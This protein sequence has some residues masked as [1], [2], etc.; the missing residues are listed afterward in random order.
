MPVRYTPPRPE[1]LLPVP[2]VRLGTAAAQIKRWQRDDVLLVGVRSRHARPPGVFTQNRFCA[3]PVIVCRQHLEGAGTSARAGR[4]RRE[5]QRRHRRGRH[6]GGRGHVRRR[7]VD[8]RLRAE[9]GAAVLDRRDHGAAAG[10]QDRRGAAAGARRARSRP[11]V[12]GGVGHHDDGHRAE[13]RVATDR[14][15]RRAGD[16]D[17][18]REGLRHDSS[19]HGHDAGL[20]R[21]RRA[22]RRGPPRGGDA[23]DRRRVV[24]LRDDRRRHVDQRQ[25][26]ARGHRTRADGADRAC[27]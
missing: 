13:R 4:E 26:R 1:D 6:R 15:R 16:G 24:Q 18:H 10:R 3:A 27:R 12:R 8:A 9:R 25:L 22:D 23:R 19:R 14:D 11:L 2:G 5:C 21:D 7:R 20:R 17:R